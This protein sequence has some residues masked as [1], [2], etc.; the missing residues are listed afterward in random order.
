[1][2]TITKIRKLPQVPSPVRSAAGRV[3][4]MMRHPAW[5]EFTAPV[6]IPIAWYIRAWIRR[7][8]PPRD[9]ERPPTPPS[10]T[11]AA[12]VALDETV[13]TV[14]RLT[15]RVPGDDELARVDDEASAAVEMFRE[16][17]WLDDPASYHD[18]PPPLTDIALRKAR[19][20]TIRY[21]VMSYDSGYAPHE[22]EPGRER[23]LADRENQTVYA[24][25]LRHPEPRPWIVCVHGAAMGQAS[26][27]L[28]VFRAAWLHT[29]LGLN[30][31]LPIQP[32]HGPRR[33]GLPIGVGFPNHDLMDT[34]HAVTQSVWD[35]RRLIGW[36]RATQGTN[37]IAVQGLSLGGYT[38]ALLAGIEPNL[39]CVILGVPVVDFAQ[40]MESH[41][42]PRLRGSAR[43]ERL[44]E[45]AP[46]VHRVIS[47]LAIEPQIPYDRR[48]IYAGLADQL[49]HP[50]HQISEI[51]RHWEE[52]DIHWFSGSHVGFF[53][54][55]PVHDFLEH[56][57]RS[58]N[59][60]PPAAADDDQELA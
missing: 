9:G 3:T 49:V 39:S 45:L 1:M 33:A 41:A 52:P 25:M 32:R 13:L 46:Q 28:R 55:R 18:V 30:V 10:L 54:S 51:A 43:L 19:S 26:A 48:F 60:L 29:V 59:M 14:A 7:I 11:L 24:W 21:T 4:A 22:G 50:I 23:W 40:L 35:I 5:T 56:A 57:L 53:V 42:G 44:T 34:V 27:D 8:S 36:I 15:Q 38:A 6:R 20:G 12:Q 2:M 31:A 58:S 37:N 16:R 17:G 47:P